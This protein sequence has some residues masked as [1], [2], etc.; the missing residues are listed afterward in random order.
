F[1]ALDAFQSEIPDQLGG[2]R[3]HVRVAVDI[4]PCVEAPRML[5]LQRQTQVLVD[6]Q[7]A[8]QVGD[9]KRPYEAE[10][11]DAERCLPLNLA[12]AE[13]H[14]AIVRREQARDQIEY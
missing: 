11:A 2:F 9:L 1:D 3:V 5:R 12:L 8:E 14:G 4:P 13:L 10:F 6:R 7:T